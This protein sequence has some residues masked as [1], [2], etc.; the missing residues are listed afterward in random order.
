M[1]DELDAIMGSRRPILNLSRQEMVLAFGEESVR[2]EQ[3]EAYSQY[4]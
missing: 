3:H 2:R 4:T 1:E